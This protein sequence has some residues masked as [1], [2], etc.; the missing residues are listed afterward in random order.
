MK[1]SR[2]NFLR[3]SSAV[4]AVSAFNIVPASVFGQNAPSNRIVM[5]MVGVGGQGQGNM[6]AFLGQSDVVVRVVCDVNEKKMADAKRKVDDRYKNSDCQMT[7]DFREVCIRKDID[8]IMIGTPDHW[9]AYIG[10]FAARNGKD[11]YGEKPFTHD[12]REGRALVNAVAHH[13]RVWQTGSQ[14]RSD[15]EMRRAV[16]LVR[17]GR[18]GKVVRVEVGLPSGGRGPKADPNAKVPEGLDWDFWVG[19]APFQPFQ[20]V[21]DWNWRWVNDWG[22]GQMMDWIGHH[23][24]IAQWGLGRDLSGPVSISGYAPFE[25]EGIYDSFKSYQYTGV[26]DDGVEITVGDGSK[27]RGGAK[28]IGAN[29]DWV[30]VDRGRYEASSP[31]IYESRIEAGELRLRS[32]GHHRNFIEAVKA[33][34]TT[35]TPAEVAHRSASVGHLGQI[36]MI[37]GRKIKWD[38]VKEEILNDPG[39]SAML[40]RTPRAPWSLT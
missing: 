9:H 24:D 11:I 39:A 35:L 32:P 19:P 13:G 10:T 38:P 25:P 33:R 12:L 26:Y 20:N 31:R 6:G 27:F 28:W 36:A 23:A 5:G 29:G 40:G 8:A 7:K 37:T 4:A 1:L 15:G 2:R 18:I 3:G 17:N 34:D 21:Y 30:W 16:E 14:Q 22:C